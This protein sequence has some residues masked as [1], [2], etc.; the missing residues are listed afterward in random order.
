M[1]VARDLEASRSRTSIPAITAVAIQ[2]A[3]ITS[4]IERYFN[5]YRALTMA[6]AE[7][8]S[9]IDCADDKGKPGLGTGAGG[10]RTFTQAGN[11]GVATNRPR[12]LAR[13][14]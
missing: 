13:R 5:D 12:L 8:H 7:K 1:F 11:P 6:A 3:A 2:E 4:L 14:Y 10:R 9:A